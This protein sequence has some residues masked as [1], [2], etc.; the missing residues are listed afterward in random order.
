MIHNSPVVANVTYGPKP[1]ADEEVTVVFA[2]GA[3][4]PY[5]TDKK[6]FFTF[7]PPAAQGRAAP[8]GF[9]PQS[10]VLARYAQGNDVFIATKTVLGGDIYLPLH[11]AEVHNVGLGL[12]IFF[13]SFVLFVVIF[14]R[15]RKRLD[16]ED[17][18]A[19]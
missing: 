16:D 15:L 2:T 10:I 7:A 19:A 13:A 5:R 14:F 4:K 9:R 6:G 1:F 12:R 17:L 8:R 3:V 11:R 18:S